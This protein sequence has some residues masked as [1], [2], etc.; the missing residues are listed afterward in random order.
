MTCISDK[1]C[2]AGEHVAVPSTDAA[3]PEVKFL[4][5]GVHSVCKEQHLSFYEEWCVSPLCSDCR[6][7]LLCEATERL[8]ACKGFGRGR[9]SRQHRCLLGTVIAE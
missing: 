5:E 8:T 6:L 3:M 7:G 1:V 4:C 2:E 9:G